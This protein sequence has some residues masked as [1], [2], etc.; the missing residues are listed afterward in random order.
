[1]AGMVAIRFG[2]DFV[3]W[4]RPPTR[5]ACHS[6]PQIFRSLPRSEGVNP[7]CKDTTIL[8]LGPDRY[9]RGRVAPS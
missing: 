3:A 7:L 1:L 8:C 2:F 5:E 9:S 4:M 6:G